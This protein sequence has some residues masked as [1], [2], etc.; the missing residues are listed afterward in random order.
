MNNIIY[1]D[2]NNFDKTLENIK[3]D[4]FEKLHV[5]ADFDNTM[6]KAFS[7]SWE[8]VASLVHLLRSV[9]KE[10][11]EDAAKEDTELFKKYHPIEIDSN[12]EIEE[13]KLKMIK[14]W[15]SSFNIFIKYWL[16]KNI[17]RKIVKSEQVTLRK[18]IVVFL[19][20]LKNHNIPLI[21]ISASW[22]WRKSI[23][24]FL[25][26]RWLLFDNINIISNDFNWDKNWNA[27]SYK[28]PIIHSFNKWETVLEDFPE[29]NKKI[30]NRTNVI[31]LWDSLWDHNMVDWFDYNNLLKIWF[32]NDN[33]DSLLK[34]YKERYDL[35]LTWD[36]EWELLEW[37]LK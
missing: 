37:L 27:I 3:K 23:S 9:E 30:K 28:E 10:L 33:E 2:K 12:I 13:K 4:W 26:E 20:F 21:I 17:L 1:T 31:L 16:N 24:Y 29:I 7:L 19:K 5:L 8:R 18:W 36:S 32:L 25:E 6:T 14:W 11:W 22:I 34:S 15:K 35:I